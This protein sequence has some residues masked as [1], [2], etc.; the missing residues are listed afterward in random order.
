MAKRR[1]SKFLRISSYVTPKLLLVFRFGG[2]RMLNFL[3]SSVVAR[4]VS[5]CLFLVFVSISALSGMTYLNLRS[6]IMSTAKEDAHS[7][8]RAMGVLYEVEAEGADIAVKDGEVTGITSAG[9]IEF[10]SHSLVDRTAE[11]ISGV[12]T[13]FN[14]SLIHI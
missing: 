12:A 3:P 10:K 4:I 2:R 8:V 9:P 7:A 5:L 11:S 1:F 6:D 14:L 13:V